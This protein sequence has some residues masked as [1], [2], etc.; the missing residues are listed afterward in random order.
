MIPVVLALF[1]SDLVTDRVSC[2]QDPVVAENTDF[3]VLEC[4]EVRFFFLSIL[5]R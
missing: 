2:M 3:L 1:D 5:G 4:M